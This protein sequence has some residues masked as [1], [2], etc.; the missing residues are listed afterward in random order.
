MVG[1]GGWSWVKLGRSGGSEVWFWWVFDVC[2]FC[3]MKLVLHTPPKKK[4]IGGKWWKLWLWRTY[5]SIIGWLNHELASSVNY[6][7]LRTWET[8]VQWFTTCVG[9]AWLSKLKCTHSSK[10]IDCNTIGFLLGFKKGG[11][12]ETLWGIFK[13]MWTGAIGNHTEDRADS[14]LQKCQNHTVL[15]NFKEQLWAVDDGI[16]SH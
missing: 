15:W 6:H 12:L 8:C 9:W 5:F 2:F 11:E 4:N 3:L 14:S 10:I 1:V 16:S 13:G 7:P